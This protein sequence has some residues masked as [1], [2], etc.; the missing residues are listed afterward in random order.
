MTWKVDPAGVKSVL[1]SVTTESAPIYDALGK[2]DATVQSAALNAQSQ[3]IASALGEFFSSIT[4]STETVQQRIPAAVD[5]AATATIA[6]NHG[7]EE[8]AATSESMAVHAATTNDFSFFDGQGSGTDAGS[9]PTPS[10]QRPG[11]A[12]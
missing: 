4:K 6:I 7:D 5:G 9:A 2:V 10:S 1:S 11:A 12:Q 3:V 8:M